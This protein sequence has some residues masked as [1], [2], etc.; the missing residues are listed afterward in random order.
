MTFDLH[1]PD[2]PPGAVIS[3]DE[4]TG[5]AT[6]NNWRELQPAAKNP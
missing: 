4:E 5:V 2:Q 3:V 1:D 6:C